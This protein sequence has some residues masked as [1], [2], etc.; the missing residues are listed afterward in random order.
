LLREDGAVFVRSEMLGTGHAE[1]IAPLVAE[2]LEEAGVTPADL[3]RIGATTG[4]GSFMGSRV[5]ISL[6]KGLALPRRL[7]TVPVTTL[8]A[9]ALG[10]PQ[11][12][13]VLIDAK[14]GHAYVQAFGENGTVPAL[15]SYREAASLA[16]ETGAVAGVGLQAIFGGGAESDRFPDIGLLAAHVAEGTP[17]VLTPLYLREADAKAP[18][19]A[20]L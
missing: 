19:R 16:E 6:A 5:G 2:L 9:I 15:L 1:R 12:V 18:S 4:P 8:E 11:P 10:M 3:T 14:R 20:P 7:P 17:G 13:C